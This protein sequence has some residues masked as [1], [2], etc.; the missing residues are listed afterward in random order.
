MNL[1]E[2]KLFG[3]YLLIKPDSYV[4]KQVGSI[5][6]P[7]SADNGP[8]CGTVMKVGGDVI[9]P[10]DMF[11]APFIEG[12]KVWYVSGYAT[13]ADFAGNGLKLVAY[14]NVIAYSSSK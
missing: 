4:Q 14:R 7:S 11:I 12:M 10:I 3:E 6:L 13:N 8:D 9:T 5:F 2:I 1:D